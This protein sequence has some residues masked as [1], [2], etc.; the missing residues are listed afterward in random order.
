MRINNQ[1]E[2]LNLIKSFKNQD[3]SSIV[4]NMV[5]E[6]AQQGNPVMKNLADLIKQGDT[7][8]IENVVRNVA[9]ERGLDYDKEF[10]AFRQM[11]RL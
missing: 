6:A 2:L 3:P 5:N 4:S 1:Q 7:K 10:K 9:K 8:Q 11:F